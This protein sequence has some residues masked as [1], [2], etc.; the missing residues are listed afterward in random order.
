[1][2]K[3]SEVGQH[4]GYSKNSPESRMAGARDCMRGVGESV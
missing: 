1:M 2:N 4:G 3:A